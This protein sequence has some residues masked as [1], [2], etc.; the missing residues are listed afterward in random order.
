MQEMG[1]DGSRGRPECV[2]PDFPKFPK[3]A[4]LPVSLFY[5]I[6]VLGNEA[7]LYEKTGWSLSARKVWNRFRTSSLVIGSLGLQ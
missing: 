1:C 5:E 3:I 2:A 7:T 4:S 6:F